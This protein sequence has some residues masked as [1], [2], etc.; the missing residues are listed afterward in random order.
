MMI[1]KSSYFS[2]VCDRAAP[3]KS[4]MG[5]GS[6]HTPVKC[7]DILYWPPLRVPTA[8]DHHS[9]VSTVAAAE[10]EEDHQDAGLNA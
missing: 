1:S 4:S 9:T 10:K 8:K 7:V 6:A 3:Q 2:H 5:M